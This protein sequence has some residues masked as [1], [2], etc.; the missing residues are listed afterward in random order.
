[1]RPDSSIARWRAVTL[2][3]ALV[4]CPF[5]ARAQP[6]AAPTQAGDDPAERGVRALRE[7]RFLDAQLA[8]EE[9]ARRTPTPA[10]W[11]NLGLA[12]RGLG[13][14]TAA[15]EVFERFLSAPPPGTEPARVQAVRDIIEALRRSLASLA[16]RVVPASAAL[17]VDDREVPLGAPL[18]LDPG[19]H[20]LEFT[21][22]EHRPERREVTLLPGGQTIFE[23]SL[24]RVSRAPGRLVIEP[25]IAGAAV[26]IDGEPAGRGTVAREV[27]PGE[28]VVEVSVAGHRTLRRVVSVTEGGTVRMDAALVPD[29]RSAR[30][31]VLPVVIAGSVVAAVGVTAL[32]VWAT[33][34]T[35]PPLQGGWET[36]H[37]S[38]VVW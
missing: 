17:R 11:F 27:P 2:A 9:A 38:I 13:R 4:A 28:H 33:R 1:M 23:L 20:V 21:A 7:R 16:V 8:L 10:T 29:A 12:Y 31:W 25:S 6:A 36:V 26:H 5:A 22:E 19:R 30:G 37:E 35:E 14:N 24:A 3:G 15:I 18:A 32:V 34:G